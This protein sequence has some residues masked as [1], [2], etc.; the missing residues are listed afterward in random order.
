MAVVAVVVRSAVSHMLSCLEGRMP[1][2]WAVSLMS[3]KPVA[4]AVPCCK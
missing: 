2:D 1:S 3:E 4:V